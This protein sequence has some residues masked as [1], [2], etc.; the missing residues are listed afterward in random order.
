MTIWTDTGVWAL[1]WTEND[2][3][4]THK[5]MEN[6]NLDTQE[7]GAFLDGKCLFGQTQ[8]DG[9]FFG[10]KMTIWTGTAQEGEGFFGRKMTI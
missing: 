8:E 10:R 7:N 5:R 9:A 2:N 6:D 4:D 1:F 3:L